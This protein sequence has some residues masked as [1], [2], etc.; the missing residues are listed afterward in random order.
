MTL[1]L[2]R[3]I[4]ELAEHNEE[5]QTIAAKT[6]EHL[7]SI[8]GSIAKDIQHVGSTAIKNIKAKPIID[9]AVAVNDFSDVEGLTPILENNG[10]MR[11]EWSGGGKEI[12]YAVGYDV[13]P[14]D[15]VTTHLIHVVKANSSEW[16]NYVNFRDYLNS[17]AIA[18]RNYEDKKIKLAA[19]N[20][21]D[22]GREKYTTGKHDFITR[23][24]SDAFIW[25]QLYDIPDFDKYIKIEP[26][27]KGWSED[28]K[29]C[30]TKENGTKYLLRVTPISRYETRKS[31]YEML[32]QVVA[33]DIPM[34]VPVEFGTCS[35]GVYS[36][37]SWINGEDLE[38][39]L[40]KLSETQ[41]YA[42]G[43]K[44]GEILRKI[45]SIPAPE[46]QED[47]EVRF[48]RKTD[49]KIEMYKNCG[50]RLDGDEHIL[51]YIKK[52]R[53]L[54]KNRPQC[55]QHDDYHVGNMMV[56]NGELVI[57]DFDR[58]D[59]GDPWEEF[60]RIVF[61]ATASPHFA[62]GQVRGYFGGEPPREFFELLTFY[63]CVNMLASLPWAIP[64]GQADID[65]MM[66]LSQDVLAWHDNMSNPVPTWYLKD[67]Y[68]Q[69]TDGVPYKLNTPYD[70]SF[71]SKYGKVFKVF[72]DQDSG[73]ICF[74][75]VDGE[76]KRFVKFAGAPTKRG[77][78]TQDEAVKR[79]KGTIQIYKDLSHP[80]LTNLLF[81][82][83]IASDAVHGGI[84][85]VFE[86]LDAECMGTQ[87]PQSR[88]K[89]MK[90]SSE[91]KLQIFD[92]IISFHLHVAKQGY[93]AIDFYDG[94]IL[95]DFIKSKTTICDVELYEKSPA[96]NNM[97]ACM[98]VPASCRQRSFNLVQP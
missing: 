94:C 55:F 1:G 77:N 47:W 69:W 60:N 8:L 93:V 37:Q 75:M 53:H 2:R 98:A 35:G 91:V 49:T 39:V 67:F 17:N 19:E 52:N 50:L 61:S 42:L 46:T 32:K 25:T 92:D 90:A 13:P 62:T 97:G 18:A 43:L 84:A 12:L 78:I 73:N 71:L 14:N 56:E 20:P 88:D 10:Y 66:K 30:V 41:A 6:I 36:L 96:K 80:I 86:W 4:V 7:S 29:Y 85:C 89:F 31:L 9:I 40:P 15:R 5:W 44:A 59:F 76:D 23:T 68:I 34:C 24:L 57:I 82:E 16:Q 70:F 54:L 64:F 63:F 33:L 48:N 21:H 83:E 26:I 38:T 51:K 3:G 72:D 22:K 65:N 27:T 87:Y 79:M 11:R 58:C 45:H 28:K 74:G 81:S 95:Y